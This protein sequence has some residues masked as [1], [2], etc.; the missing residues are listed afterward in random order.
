MSQF[1]HIHLTSQILF[2]HTN[3]IFTDPSTPSPKLTTP[4]AIPP[5]PTHPNA[6]SKYQKRTQPSVSPQSV[7]PTTGTTSSTTKHT[8]ITVPLVLTPPHIPLPADVQQAVSRGDERNSQDHHPPST[9]PGAGANTLP[10]GRKRRRMAL[11]EQRSRILER[12]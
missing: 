11:L 10:S 9:A 8:P 5:T 6:L 12:I 4:T 1:F 2:H 3:K 7:K